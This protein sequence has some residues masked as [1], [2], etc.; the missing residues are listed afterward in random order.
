MAPSFLD[1][2]AMDIYS[3]PAAHASRA[4][5]V[6]KPGTRQMLLNWP[7]QAKKQNVTRPVSQQNR[8]QPTVAL[9]HTIIPQESPEGVGSVIETL[10]VPVILKQ[11][12]H[13]FE[14]RKGSLGRPSQRSSDAPCNKL[15][16]TTSVSV[17]QKQPGEILVQ[18]KHDGHGGG[19]LK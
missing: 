6:S 3:F 4:V 14:W 1:Y 11:R 18:T 13:P 9:P 10:V 17:T 16:R 15:G 12:L 19:L 7:T 5:M 8:D 2:L